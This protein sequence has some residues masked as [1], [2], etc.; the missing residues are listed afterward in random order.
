[1]FVWAFVL[2]IF[3]GTLAV[4]EI[5]PGFSLSDLTV[6]QRGG[7]EEGPE[8]S[9]CFV[10]IGQLCVSETRVNRA[11]WSHKAALIKGVYLSLLSRFLTSSLLLLCLASLAD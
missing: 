6:G 4:G 5:K 11:V 10:T 3:F 1:M 9:P 2:Q 7:E 8:A